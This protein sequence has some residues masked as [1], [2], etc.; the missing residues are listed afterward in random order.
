MRAF[1]DIALD[2]VRRGGD[3]VYLLALDTREQCYTDSWW[4]MT[5][6]IGFMIAVYCIGTLTVFT[7]LLVKTR[8]TRDNAKNLARVRDVS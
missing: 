2:C 5:G 8:H 7:V 1:V 3:A 6:I 4:N